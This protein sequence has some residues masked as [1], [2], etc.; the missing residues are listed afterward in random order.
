[1]FLR[2]CMV[3]YIWLVYTIERRH[4]EWLMAMPFTN[5]YI[6]HRIVC[7]TKCTHNTQIYAHNRWVTMRFRVNF[8]QICVICGHLNMLCLTMLAWR[9]PGLKCAAPLAARGAAHLSFCRHGI[10]HRLTRHESQHDL[11]VSRGYVSKIGPWLEANNLTISRRITYQPYVHVLVFHK[12]QHYIIIIN[13]C[14][15]VAMM[16]LNAWCDMLC[17]L[18][19][20][21]IS[22]KRVMFAITFT[23]T[24]HVYIDARYMFTLHL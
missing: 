24:T 17:A 10:I 19:M 13:T 7:C 20:T 9:Q 4:V 3:C 15:L 2:V 21:V 12:L 8:G 23:T 16:H 1:M 5:S 22:Y 11:R 14:V 18:I 6:T